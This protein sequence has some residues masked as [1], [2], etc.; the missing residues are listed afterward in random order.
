MNIKIEFGNKIKTLRKNA[1]ISQEKLADL[2]G[3]D[4]T[5]ISSIEKGERNVS[6]VIIE[7]L[8]QALKVSIKDFF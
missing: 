3:I 2:A 1:G 5:Y 8:S 4:R 7:K 6:V